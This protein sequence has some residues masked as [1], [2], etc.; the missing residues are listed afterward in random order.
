VTQKKYT[1][2]QRVFKAVQNIGNGDANDTTRFYYTQEGDVVKASYEGGGIMQG[3]L[4]AKILADGRLDMRYHHV[5][6][7]GKLMMGSCIS[8]PESGDDGILRLHEKWHGTSGDQ[9]EGTSI[10]EEI[11]NAWESDRRMLMM[12]AYI[13]G[14]AR[15]LERALFRYKHRVKLKPH[16]VDSAVEASMEAQRLLEVLCAYQNA[17]GGFGKGIE[18][19]FLMAASSPMAT[20]I[21]LRYLSIVEDL[22]EAQKHI[23]M[24]IAYLEKTFEL[25][26]MG[27]YA[28]N[29][30]VNKAPHAPWWHYDDKTHQTA[31][32]ESYGNPTA[33][34]LGY[35]YRYRYLVQKLPLDQCI[36][37]AITYFNEKTTYTS[38]H[39]VYCFIR[40]Y[41]QLP[42]HKRANLREAVKRAVRACVNYNIEDWQKYVA[43]PLHFLRG[44]PT[45][46]M[47]LDKMG[48]KLNREYIYEQVSQTGGFIDTTWS[49]GGD[50]S[51]WQLSKESWRG[52]LTLEAYEAIETLRSLI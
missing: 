23:A 10:I 40:L 31:I 24:G 32:D 17:D 14:S 12:K 36:D 6:K 29:E 35:L 33:E 37:H 50:T 20:S 52:I 3:S 22:P 21:G 34:L 49:W 42:E 13:L 51:A 15:P 46:L 41:E 30:N 16:M 25:E 26:R 9:S 39:E 27:W 47:G 8:T 38:E 11:P 48:L 18:P 4:I 19:D 44:T 2:H 1:Y 43:M 5:N 28:V 7:A 45:G